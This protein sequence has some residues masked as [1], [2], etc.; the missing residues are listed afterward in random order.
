MDANEKI[1]VLGGTGHFGTRICRRLADLSGSELIIA[2]RDALRA[3]VLADELSESN[4]DT[5]ITARALDQD[6]PEFENEL[7]AIRPFV[8][9]HTAGPY[10]GQDYRVAH[11]CI[12]AG[13]HYVDLA[14]ARDF[15]AEFDLLDH[16]AKEAGVLLVSGASTLPSVAAAV[17]E[18][19]R[20]KFNK[21]KN[22]EISIAPAQQTPRGL[23]TVAAVL[24]YCGR[25][26]EVLAGG[27][28]RAR[29]GWQ[30]LRFQH[31]PALGRRLSGACDVPDL[32]LL[33]R[34]VPDVLGVSFHAALESRLEQIA[35]WLMAWLTRLGMVS[36]WSSHA[37]MFTRLS[38]QLAKL[39][40]DR[41]A[42][43]V[44]LRGEGRRGDPLVLDW[45]LTARD[46]H[47]PEIPC[48]PS[49]VITKKL[50]RDELPDRGAVPCMG[51][52]TLDELMAEMADFSIS[53]D[54]SIA[55]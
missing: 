38:R 43:R 4:P 51:L 18:Q 24:S 55:S 47:G 48:T 21:I 53:A 26:F 41:G 14:D 37:P 16:M 34:L 28:W 6:S 22:I 10:Q 40:S 7:C 27:R 30:D 29:Y 15:V 50:L 36:D 1:L 49:I 52:F 2:G 8:V 25:P 33:P 12:E 19:H 20:E 13:C 23:G 46:N 11:A 45:N 9:I 54:V 32:E 31:Y 42:M 39:G 44:T 35:L 3:E 5:T 17:I